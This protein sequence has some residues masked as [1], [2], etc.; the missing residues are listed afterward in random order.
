MQRR[1]L[2]LSGAWG[3]RSELEQAVGRASYRT[4]GQPETEADRTGFLP[5]PCRGGSRNRS[6]RNIEYS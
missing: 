6:R 4:R 2:K 3:Q 1:A 5:G